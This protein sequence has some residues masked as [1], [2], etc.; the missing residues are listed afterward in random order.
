M[1]AVRTPFRQ[2]WMI[3]RDGWTLVEVLVAVAVAAVLSAAAAGALMLVAR[4]DQHA[5][6]AEELERATRSWSAARGWV[7]AAAWSNG[8]PAGV[9]AEYHEVRDGSGRNA[10]EWTL[11][12]LVPDQ[13]PSFR[14]RLWLI[15]RPSELVREPAG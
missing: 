10:V 7:S 8:Q 3:G 4:L 5:R 2:R 15:A 1:P 13:R 12:E 6:L 11:W 9:R 14:V